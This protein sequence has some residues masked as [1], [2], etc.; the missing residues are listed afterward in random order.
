M[1]APVTPIA[2]GGTHPAT[3]DELRTAVRE[4]M[5]TRAPLADAIQRGYVGDLLT[6][7]ALPSRGDYLFGVERDGM[8]V[9]SANRGDIRKVTVSVDKVA[10]F[11]LYDGTVIVAP[12]DARLAFGKG[13]Q[14]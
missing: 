6:N 8:T 14:L 3:A 13:E 10:T 7:D 2:K 1:S 5:L 9:S 4:K 11:V 12:A